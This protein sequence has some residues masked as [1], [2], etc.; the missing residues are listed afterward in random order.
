PWSDKQKLTEE[1]IA[2]GFYLSGHLFNAY[3]KEVR[4]FARGKLAELS[5]S[6]DPKMIAGMITSVRTQMT[7]RGKIVIVTLD[8]NTATVDVTVYNDLFDANKAIFKEDEFL[9]VLG[10]VSEDRFSGGLR[11]TA[12]K[13]MDIVA[14]RLQYGLH[15]GGPLAGAIEPAKLREALTPF[16]SPDG[17]PVVLRYT[18]QDSDEC[19][20]RLGD[21]WR[22]LPAD[23]LQLALAQQAGIKDAA[24]CYD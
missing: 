8:D 13:A 24:V 10:K 5:P 2:L 20:L 16:K 19:E 9:A 3:A 17:L 14:C 4:R 1:K 12:E 7:Q 15:F 23:G 11:V 18:V 21:E 22:V 6:R